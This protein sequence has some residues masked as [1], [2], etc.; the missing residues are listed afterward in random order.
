MNIH[1]IT[2]TVVELTPSGFKCRQFPRLT[3]AG[4]GIAIVHK[5]TAKVN[6]SCSQ[7][8]S[9][10]EW[11]EI[12]VDSKH[13]RIRYILMYRPPPSFS[14][15]LTSNGF[16]SDFSDLLDIYVLDTTPIVYL[17][18]FNIHFNKPDNRDTCRFLELLKMHDL[19]Q[20]VDKP[21]HRS[22]NILDL[23]ITRENIV[24]SLEV[25]QAAAISDHYPIFF[26]L[27]NHHD[28]TS[29]RTKI[30]YRSFKNFDRDNFASD[31]LESGCTRTVDQVDST[32][33]LRIF[34]TAVSETLDK[35][36]PMTEKTVH[37]RVAEPWINVD[38]YH[39]R[40][41]RRK[42]ER[43][44]RRTGLTVHRQ[45]YKS[46]RNK[47]ND[48][49]DVSRRSYFA[50]K[51]ADCNG[52]QRKLFSIVNGLLGSTNNLNALPIHDNK[53]NLANRFSMFFVDKIKKINQGLNLN[54]LN[55]NRFNELHKFSGD[56]LKC[57]EPATEDEI[58]KIIKKIVVG[59]VRFGLFT[60]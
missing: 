51:I 55:G 57:F 7:T 38:I 42:A 40:T 12:T 21:T 3:G 8:F 17:G 11:L 19:V 20:L 24:L 50:D 27:S 49:I 30:T 29:N 56:E 22:G 44:W 33:K 45:I 58:I 13:G 46:K 9:S 60:H 4:G 48:L 35:H 47:V 1:V 37:V 16:L 31:L 5:T 26:S 10:F 6:T 36:A 59:F 53:I 52:D 34:N 43:T 41:E 14:N 25:N 18:D 54:L 32:A 15:K 2:F 23:I 39:A 28:N